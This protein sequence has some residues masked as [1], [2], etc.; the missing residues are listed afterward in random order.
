MSAL[1]KQNNTPETI[2][3]TA[4]SRC[5][6]C[7]RALA[8]IRLCTGHPAGGGG[9]GGDKASE[10]QTALGLSKALER[11]L[12][13]LNENDIDV[14]PEVIDELKRIEHN[15]PHLELLDAD[16]IQELIALH[17]LTIDF[18]PNTG[19]LSI[20]CKPEL[21]NPKQLEL[22]ATFIHALDK[23]FKDYGISKEN[24]S[25]VIQH[26]IFGNI[27]SLNICIN[28]PALFDQFMK[29]L[30][31]FS[32]VLFAKQQGVLNQD[33]HS[34]D[35][36]QDKNHFSPTPLSTQCKPSSHKGEE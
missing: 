24:G 29:S 19:T 27:K 3:R 23:F 7:K 14:T 1:K 6:Q 4:T 28:K 22:V 10:K 11:I 34:H 30:Q 20:T 16:K 31:V 15:H 25:S 2:E 12:K 36:P 13:I 35:K 32:T 17:L 33:N 26:D 5:G 9:S 8:P 18:K 21:M